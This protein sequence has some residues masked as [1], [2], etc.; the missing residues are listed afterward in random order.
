[1]ITA[2]PDQ[3]ARLVRINPIVIVNGSGDAARSLRYRGKHT[4]RALIGFLGTQRDA[5]ALVYSHNTDGSQLWVDV[6]TGD[7]SPLLRL[8]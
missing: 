8:H 3:I 2:T 4:M 1:M 6:Q 7:F 5:R